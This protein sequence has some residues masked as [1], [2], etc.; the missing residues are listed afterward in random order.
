M[1]TPSGQYQ[2]QDYIAE[3]QVRGFDGFSAADLTSYV[4]RGYFHVAR[5]SQWMWEST[6]DPFTLTPGQYNLPLW[7]AGGGELPFV[8]SIDKIVVTTPGQ[9]RKLKVLSDDQFYPY[10]GMDLTLS[11]FRG[12]PWAYYV[13]NQALYI[14]D[15]PVSSRSFLAYYKRRMSP[16]VNPTDVPLT[17]QHMDEANLLAALIRCHRRAN[18]PSLAA[19][20]EADLEEFFDDARDDEEMMMGEQLDRVSPDN[21]WL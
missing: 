6:T 16:L 3:L 7:P 15:P 13:W 4:N 2:L 5:R 20:A 19:S 17:P 14:I 9:T 21:S 11:Q 1:P 8:R 12:E 18:E 10:L